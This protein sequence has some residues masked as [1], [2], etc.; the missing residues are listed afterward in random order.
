MLCATC[1]DFC[2]TF[3]LDDAKSDG[4]KLQHLTYGDLVASAD[5]GCEIC[6]EIRRQRKNKAPPGT[7]DDK[8]RAYGNQIRCVFRGWEPGLV[9]IQGDLDNPYIAYMD[10]CTVESKFFQTDIPSNTGSR[11]TRPRSEDDHRRSMASIIWTR[12]T[13]EDA[14]SPGIGRQIY[15]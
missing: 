2:N 10:V 4:G 7:N 1:S 14:W 9:W 3:D 8:Y 11:F 12:P 15:K 6:I 5:S 13:H